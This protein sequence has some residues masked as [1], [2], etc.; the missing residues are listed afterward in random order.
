MKSKI[1]KPWTFY[2]LSFTWG[3]IVTIGGFL[4]A[5]LFLVTGHLPKRCGYCFLFESKRLNGGFSA[6]IF[7]FAGRGASMHLLSHEHGHGVQNCIYGPLMPLL[8]SIPSSTRYHFRNFKKRF[9]KKAPKTP[10]ESV[11]FEKEATVI[12]Q[13]YTHLINR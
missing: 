9:F 7:I 12:G 2:T 13:R 6:G 4:M 8:V 3:L 5:F 10:Y 1:I 11:W